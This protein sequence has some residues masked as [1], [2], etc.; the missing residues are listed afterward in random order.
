MGCKKFRM[1]LMDDA[2]GDPGNPE[3]RLLE[4]HL[5]TCSECSRFARYV[6]EFDESVRRETDLAPDPFMGA[7]ALAILENKKKPQSGFPAL[8]R[9]HYLVPVAALVII[10]LAGISL[11]SYFND[12]LNLTDD[13]RTEIYYLSDIHD[14]NIETL[15]FDE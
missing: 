3:R 10:V 12:H 15:L 1:Q 7:R 13:Y 2:T 5:T 11:G 9:V 14:E 8:R 6:Q 4:E